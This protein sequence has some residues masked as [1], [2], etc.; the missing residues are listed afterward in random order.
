ME[1]VRSCLS[2]GLAAGMVA[3]AALASPAPARPLPALAA[4]AI[5]LSAVVAALPQPA[6]GV[7]PT[8]PAAGPFPTGP[9]G[10]AGE[11]IINAY[12]AIEPWVQYSVELGAWAVSWLPWPIGL[13][14]PQMNIAYNAIQPITQ[15]SVYSLAYLIDGEF[16]LIGPTLANGVRTGVDNLVRGEASW[17]ASFFPPLPPRTRQVLAGAAKAADRPAGPATR[18]LA[19]VPAPAPEKVARPVIREKVARTVA[20]RGLGRLR[21]PAPAP[22]AVT[23]PAGDL[24]S[25]PSGR[26][27]RRMPG[28]GARNAAKARAANSVRSGTAR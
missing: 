5:H 11:G 27:V 14:A 28:K 16:D 20:A 3:A 1:S 10:S 8:K 18:A 4:P 7:R 13:A 9:A 17:I 6:A 26:A 25:A 24:A 22:A 2:V 21:N 19:T 23:A 15:A 12:N